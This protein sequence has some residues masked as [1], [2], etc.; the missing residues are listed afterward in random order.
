MLLEMQL[1]GKGLVKKYW[2]GRAGAER[3]WV[4]SFWALSKGWV[5]QFPATHGGVSSYFIT[6]IGKKSGFSVL[7]IRL[8]SF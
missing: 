5:V 8:P 7:V 6:G 4:I 3:G 2:V 1:L